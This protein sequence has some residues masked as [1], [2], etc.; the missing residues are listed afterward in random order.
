MIEIVKG[1][2]VINMAEVIDEANG[3]NEETRAFRATLLARS[4]AIVRYMPRHARRESIA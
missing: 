2:N 4:E 1:E 3:V